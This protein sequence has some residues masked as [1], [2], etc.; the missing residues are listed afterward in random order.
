V[1]RIGMLVACLL[2]GALQATAMDQ[3]LLDWQ[4]EGSATQGARFAKLM[5]DRRVQELLQQVAAEPRGEEFVSECLRS[6][7]TT[8]AELVDLKL[9]RRVGDRY[10]IGFALL[11][12][13]DLD[14]IRTV[15]EDEGRRLAAAV[16]TRRSEFQAALART[17][18]VGVDPK[19]V[20]FFAIG[21]V[22]LDWDGLT[23]T[24]ELGYRTEPKA[25]VSYLPLAWQTEGGGS[26][27]GLYWGSHSWTDAIT[28]T[29][30]GDH[31]GVSRV[32]FPDLGNRIRRALRTT[33]LPDPLASRLGS[34]ADDL[35]RRHLA[36]MMVALRQGEKTTA[37]LAVAAELSKSETKG[38]LDLALQLHYVA[39]DGDAYRA[40]IPVLTEV[41]APM[42][43]EVRRLGREAMKAWFVERQEP[44]R[45]SLAGLS[46]VRNGVSLQ[47]GF[48][49]VWHYVFGVANRELAAAGL[50]VD[51]YGDGSRFRGFLPVVWLNSVLRE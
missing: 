8:A 17:S 28:F 13:E 1:L 42:L 48:Y 5:E 45:R 21:C 30:F 3:P 31:S 29:T 39:L 10:A 12:R 16:L 49:W 20:A 50:L 6:S 33:D 36:L 4:Y 11:T 51:P 38:L 34:I 24:S 23:L 19:A 37:E 25:D 14:L 7:T 46:F 26:K 44:L 35:I 15:A 43:R 41:D 22:S 18:Q 47:D 27:R 40:T 2:A 9:V 32:A